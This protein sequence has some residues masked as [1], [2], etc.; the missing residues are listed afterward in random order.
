MEL[1][2]NESIEN[3]LKR[4]ELYDL[5]AKKFIIKVDNGLARSTE[6]YKELLHALTYNGDSNE[7]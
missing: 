2:K 3:K 5:A 4:L 6:T 7:K 1:P